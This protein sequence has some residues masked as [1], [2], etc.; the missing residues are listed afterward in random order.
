MSE[1]S[2]ARRVDDLR[3]LSFGSFV[4]GNTPGVVLAELGADVVK[5]EALARPEVLRN[6]AYGFGLQWAIEPSGVP[7]TV[8]YAGLARSMR[9]LSLEMN[10]EQGRALFRR[11]V[12]VADVVIENFGSHTM[13]H[14]GCSFAELLAVNPRL[15][16]LSLSGYGRTGPRAGYLAYAANI[17]NFTGLTSA[18]TFQHGTHSDYITAV[19]G[20]TAVLAALA[21]VDRTG[22]GVSIDIA[23]TEALGALMAPVYLDPLNRGRDTPPTG[24]VV[25]GA[26]F[27]GAFRAQGHDRWLAV[28]LED[29]ADWATLCDVLERPDLAVGGEEEADERRGALEGAVAEWTAER[30]PHTAAQLLQRAGLAASAVYDSEDVVRDPQL[31][32]RGAVVEIDQPD[33]G[34]I[35]HYQSPYRLSKTP[36]S[37]RRPGARLGQHTEAV[38]REWLEVDDAELGTLA[39]AGAVWQAPSD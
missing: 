3:V 26:L 39:A 37:M 14:W 8:M 11:L 28:E 31:R 22:L 2:V 34:V 18:W 27:A 10:T 33:L 23:Q 1:T 16:M 30:S 24:N 7:N 21:E 38:L 32:T 20:A 17:C 6:P 5:I 25:P 9:G 13:E 29:L 12:A 15:V 19:H 4:A 36:G 35:E